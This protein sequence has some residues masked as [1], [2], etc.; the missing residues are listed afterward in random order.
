[1]CSILPLNGQ[2]TSRLLLRL[3]SRL[4]NTLAGCCCCCPIDRLVMCNRRPPG[5]VAACPSRAA[6][7][8]SPSSHSDSDSYSYS[9]AGSSALA[10]DG[11]SQNQSPKLVREPSRSSFFKI[12]QRVSWRRKIQPAHNGPTEANDDFVTQTLSAAPFAA[13]FSSRLLLLVPYAPPVWPQ[14][15]FL[16]QEKISTIHSFTR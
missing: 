15:L 10:R 1:M 16:P 2:E 6:A 3:H 11:R 8:S 9:S 12:L 4:T 7:C 5:S 14:N 13:T